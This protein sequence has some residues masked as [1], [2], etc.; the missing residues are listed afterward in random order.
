MAVGRFALAAELSPSSP[1][2]QRWRNGRH[3]WRHRGEPGGFDAD[4]YFVEPITEAVAKDFVIATHYSGTY[5]ASAQRWGMRKVD[6][7]TLVGVAVLGIPMSNLVLSNVFPGLEPNV[8]ALELSRFVLV[9]E[10]PANGETFFLARL[11]AGAAAMGVQGIVAFADPVPRVVDGRTVFPGHRGGI[12]CAKG[13]V[14]LGRSTRRTLIVLPDGKV[15]PARAAQKVRAGE[16][17]HEHVE[18][19]LVAL[20]ATPR[21][22][23]TTG[24]AWLATGLDE[25]GAIRL[26]HP[27]NHRYAFRLGPN[28]RARAKVE[29]APAPLP[30]PKDRAA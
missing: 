8:S 3:S 25:I 9:D 12:Y 7:A 22:G 21:R 30:Y 26:T 20:G 5:P 15:L 28:A 19:R 17:G 1:W 11:F 14:Y 4:R 10:V 13:A 6:G 29:I 18:A 24:A 2:C 23:T 16:S 27:G